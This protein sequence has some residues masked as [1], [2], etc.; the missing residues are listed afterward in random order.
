MKISIILLITSCHSPATPLPFPS[1]PLPCHSLP[2][3]SLP[4]G[5]QC[6]QGL[7]PLV[8][9]PSP[10]PNALR[11]PIHVSWLSV[12]CV[13]HMHMMSGGVLKRAQADVTSTVSRITSL[14]RLS[15]APLT[16][17]CPGRR[18]GFS[19]PVGACF[20]GLIKLS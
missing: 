7:L 4:T 15:V 10:E 3:H 8:L 1:L 9:Q 6:L 17:L 13:S 20:V 18:E 14:N 11:K 5:P 16:V 19:S 2:C 12:V